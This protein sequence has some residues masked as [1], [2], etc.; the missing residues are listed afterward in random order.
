MQFF[1]SKLSLCCCRKTIRILLLVAW[2]KHWVFRNSGKKNL[3]I[4]V[5]RAPSCAALESNTCKLNTLYLWVN[6]NTGSLL[7][8]LIRST[9]YSHLIVYQW[10]STFIH[11]L[12]TISHFW[13]WR[14]WQLWHYYFKVRCDLWSKQND[15]LWTNKR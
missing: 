11:C 14:W 3:C 4:L 7:I 10:I 6:F 5:H 1:Y 8:T 2:H 9:R 15:R 12:S 13:C